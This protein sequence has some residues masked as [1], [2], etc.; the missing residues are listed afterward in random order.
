MSGILKVWVVSPDTHSERRIDPHI[1]VE[2]LKGKLEPITG[3]P[4]ANQSI[5]I[6]A[7]EL[8]PRVLASLTDDSKKLGYYG[9]ADWQVLKVVDTNPSSSLTGQLTD[10]TQVDKFEL[11]PEE[12]AQRRDTVLAYKQRNKVGRFAEN[13]PLAEPEMA[14][15]SVNI[16][17]GSRC[18]IESL[19]PGLSKRGTVRFVGATKFSKGVWVGVEYDEPLGKN[20]GAV[21]GERYFTCAPNYGVFVKPEKVTVGEYPVEELEIEMEDEEM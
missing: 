5:T 6:L 14:P 7:S 9:L 11:S 19:E 13:E 1:T 4:A 15:E 3:I 12:Y 20:D 18:E 2:Q 16:P 21:Q 17:V 10:V 8:D